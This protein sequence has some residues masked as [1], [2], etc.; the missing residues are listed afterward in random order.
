MA[1]RNRVRRACLAAL[2]IR[3]E[4]A[5]AAAQP[6]HPLHHF[7]V[8]IGLAGGR[9]VAGKIGSADQ[10]QVTVFGPVV[11]LA[12]RL[13][14]LTRSLHAEI[15]VDAAT[16]AEANAR[17][18]PQLG[19]TRPIATVRPKGMAQ[20]VA[21][22]ELLPA[23]HVPAN[24]DPASYGRI[25]EHF[26]AGRWREAKSLTAELPIEAQWGRF[27]VEWIERHGDVAPQDWNGVIPFE[28]K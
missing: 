5:A 22:H 17:L 11:N 28:N 18:E 1:A 2:E 26:S 3:R 7:R 13:E 24:V 19:A 14:G 4:F 6:E 25:L 12:Q 23:E 20:S 10:V 16:A 8:G 9:A 27:L 21:V 15:L